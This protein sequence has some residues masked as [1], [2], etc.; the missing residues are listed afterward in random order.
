MTQDQITPALPSKSE[1]PRVFRKFDITSLKEASNLMASYDS[2][3]FAIYSLTA[4]YFSTDIPTACVV[5]DNKSDK[6]RLLINPYFWEKLDDYEKQFIIAH[7]CQHI[8]LNHG[9]ILVENDLDPR[10]ANTA[11]DISVNE[12]LK[13]YY[14]FDYDLM[15][16]IEEAL[17]E[18][19]EDEEL[20]NLV[21]EKNLNKLCTVD[22]VFGENSGIPTNKTALYY[23][24]LLFEKHKDSNEN[25]INQAIDQHDGGGSIPQEILD[26]IIDR[27]IEESNQQDLDNLVQSLQEANPD[28]LKE[29]KALSRL[30]GSE[31]GLETIILPIK[32]IKKKRKWETVIKR[33]A[34]D[35]MRTQFAPEEQWVMPNRRWADITD[36]I[37]PS[38]Y[39]VESQTKDKMDVW[40]FQDV[41]GSCVHLVERFFDAALSIPEERFNIRAF[42]F[43]TRTHEINLKKREVKGGGGTS[44]TCLE[45]TIQ[46]KIQEEGCKYPSAVFVITDGYGDRMSAEYP[47]RWFWFLTDDY[48][49]QPYTDCIPK[50]SHIFKLSDYE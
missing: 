38:E 2:V 16:N 14:D 4:S 5:F 49:G 36:V 15:D 9:S 13:R 23:Y 27:I 25:S 8:L 20:K 30:A 46:R 11:L 19:I 18:S 32:V 45:N 48:G 10:F 33:W 29:N 37:L 43:D 39:V 24:Q 12:T 41:S 50:Q 7:E 3:F 22:T 17:L 6:L 35:K 21:K 42:C 28:A 31:P 40:F 1:K 26:Q 47:D 44:F 34:K